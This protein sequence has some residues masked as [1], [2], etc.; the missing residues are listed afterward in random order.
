[1]SSE[2]FRAAMDLLSRRKKEKTENYYIDPKDNEKVIVQTASNI[3]AAYIQTGQVQKGT[4][5][6]FQSKAIKEAVEIALSV[7]RLVSDA[8]EERGECT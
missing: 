6:E 7:E 1:M 3:Y 5:T 4:E 2:D 8:Q